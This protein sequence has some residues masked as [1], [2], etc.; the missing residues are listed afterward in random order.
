MKDRDLNYIGGKIL[1]ENG[2]FQGAI[3][4]FINLV[5]EFPENVLFRKFLAVCYFK[6]YKLD[7]F[8]REILKI[9]LLEKKFIDF[10]KYN[11]D[12][13]VKKDVIFEIIT[14]IKNKKL[15]RDIIFNLSDFYEP[16]T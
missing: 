7:L 11:I 4:H 5:R 1:F 6:I 9:F 2:N 12:E 13:I 15:I 16:N 3:S 10:K 14:H 8:H